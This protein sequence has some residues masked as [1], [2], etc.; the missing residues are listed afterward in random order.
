MIN[1]FGYWDRVTVQ[2]VIIERRQVMV[3]NLLGQG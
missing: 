1:Q 3:C 2:C